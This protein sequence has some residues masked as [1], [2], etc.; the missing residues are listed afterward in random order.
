MLPYEYFTLIYFDRKHV[1]Y[2]TQDRKGLW[3]FEFK[4]CYYK[5]GWSIILQINVI[6]S[7]IRFFKGK[8]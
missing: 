3:T 7:L 6:L 1:V 8:I 2:H 4:K 5:L